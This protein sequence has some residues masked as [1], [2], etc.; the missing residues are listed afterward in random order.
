M[1]LNVSMKNVLT[2]TI[3]V[4]KLFVPRAEGKNTPNVSGL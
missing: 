3:Q 4:K 2:G 1:T